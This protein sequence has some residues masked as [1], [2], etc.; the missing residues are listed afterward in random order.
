MSNLQ[1][2][3]K[4]VAWLEQ[5]GLSNSQ[6]IAEMYFGDMPIDEWQERPIEDWGGAL[7]AHWRFGQCRPEG[8]ALLRIYNP[9]QAE[10]GWQCAHTV[11]E[12]VHEDMPFLVD[13][14]GM[15]LNALKYN[16]LAVI[17]PVIPL[18]RD[19]NGTVSQLQVGAT[20]ES[21]MHFEL[22][23]ISDPALLTTLQ[24]Q[25][26]QALSAIA[27]SVAD[28]SK[29]LGGVEQTLQELRSGELADSTSNVKEAAA[30]LEWLLDGHFVFLGLRK[31]KFVAGELLLQAGSGLG[32]LRDH[33]GSDVV[34]RIWS[35]LSQEQ[36]DI[37]YANNRVVMLTKSD[38]RS[39]IHRPAYLD[40]ILVRTLDQTGQ[41]LGETRIV[42][43]YSASAYST[44]PRQIPILRQKIEH[45][46]QNSGADLSGYRGKALLNTLETYPRDELIEIEVPEL[47]RI[48][49]GIVSLH[50][51]SRVRVF[52]RDDIYQRYVS[53]MVFVPRDNYSTEVRIKIETLLL[54]KLAGTSAEYTVLLGEAPLARLHYLIRRPVG[55]RGAYDASLIEQEIANLAQ[56][57]TDGL[58]RELIHIHGEEKGARLYQKYQSGFSAAY[59]ADFSPR[60]A[61]HDIDALEQSQRE[62]FAVSLSAAN[63][64]DPTIWRF[65]LYRQ[66][67]IELSDCLPLLE[68]LGLRV[69]DERP[70]PVVTSDHEPL[71]IMDIGIRLPPGASLESPTERQRMMD[72]F[73][74]L[75]NGQAENDSFN[76]LTLLAGL[77]WREVLILRAYARFLKQVAFKYGVETI[78]DCLLKYPSYSKQLV[79]A[80]SMLH[81]PDESQ[82]GVAEIVLEEIEQAA[83]VL[84]N[85]D[86]ERILTGFVQSVRATLR[87]NFFQ[88]HAGLS[89]PYLALKIA[90]PQLSFM[91]Q[92]VPMCE[93]FVYSPQLEGVHLRGGKV[94]RGGLRWSDRR[95]D[96]RTEVLG[97]VKAQMVKNTVIVPVGS[98]G[99]FIV[100]NPPLD[101]D[102][103]LAAGTR[104][105][106]TFIGGL[107]D[108]TDNLR[109]GQIIPPT[110]VRRRD[111]D[112]P[113]LVV[114]ADK[115]TA[116]FSD[117]ANQIAQ[118]YGFWLDDAFA[119]GGSVGYDHKKMG[120]T[121]R[122]AWV[123]VERSFRELGLDTRKEPFSVV[124]IGDM[125][126]DVFGN[127]LLRSPCAKLVAAFD[128]RHIFIDPAPDL[129]ISFAERNRLFVLP[130]SSWADYNPALI[131]KGGGVW[132]RSAKT[133]A[134]ST[135]IKGMLGVEADQLEPSVLIQ[136]ILKAP[137]DLLYNG[138]IG[139]Y[140]KA[141]SQS[142]AEANDRGN[143]AVRIDGRDL[144]CRV[145]AEGGN[146]GFT[147]LGR[148]EYAAQGGRIYTDAI[149]NSA[150]V[151]CSDHEVNIKIL[152]GKLIASGDLTLKQ[153]NEIL[154][155]MTED[156][157]LQVLRD[158]ELQTLAISLEHQQ[159]HSLLSVHTRL[160]SH[161]EKAGKLSRRI[162]YLP[163]DSALAE[164]Q[165]AG[166]GLYRPELAVLL[167]YAKIVLNQDLLAESLIDNPHWDG[168]LVEY[169]PS[170][171]SARF[172]T[173]I[174]S[175]P[176]RREI[177]ATI[178][179]NHIVNRFGLS[180]VYR[181]QEETECSASCV[182]E[183]FYIAEQLLNSESLAQ[184]VEALDARAP[185]EV[186]IE[187]LL[188]I[189][190]YTERVARWLLMHPLNAAE[191]DHLHTSAALT[192][193]LAPEWL[194]ASP[195][196]QEQKSLLLNVGV[197]ADLAMKVLLLQEI[198]PLLE[199]ARYGNDTGQLADRLKLHLALAEQLQLTWL[200]GAIEQLPRANRWQTL[201]R[202]AV[203]DD[204]A[205]FQTLL[206]QQVWQQGQN[207]QCLQVWLDSNRLTIERILAMFAELR[208]CTP[209]LAMI[210]AAVRELRQ[211]L[212]A[213]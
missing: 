68:N 5:H 81:H 169:F 50:E 40:T 85:I 133:I 112:D 58:K 93:I 26:E 188:Q 126:G 103:L 25:I 152:L 168:V 147:Q 107:L 43:L 192:L 123:S 91:P 157:G 41:L 151:D 183:A 45:V 74:A 23:R 57:W 80:F 184:E 109:D 148:V 55:V 38:R 207:E 143:D 140:V 186:Q 6:Q 150:G 139:T 8:E 97:L 2:L 208:S 145:V 118:E 83:K 12:I 90:S 100:K 111:G 122:G 21:W 98:K 17:H 60:I 77:A 14:V 69:L 34:S 134:L 13:S 137:V 64:L 53:V 210:S 47:T 193:P 119:S 115:G 44:P 4:L 18:S 180:A 27:A 203:R 9:S 110:N 135:E 161:L 99:G 10:H 101:R 105:Y 56:R 106:Q 79:N 213:A 154:V 102:A 114:A 174:A 86:E 48:A 176:L 95:E 160:M 54:E 71:S 76:R 127:G 185:A 171:L 167:A 116:T 39:I 78:A 66:H 3:S 206:T 191:S 198:Q 200:H 195:R 46:V 120:I 20:K 165:A 144:R 178:L 28:W 89:K 29:M 187:L 84:P 51:R 173:A 42:G 22:N 124:G 155:S 166:L 181:L 159:A 32:V 130:R 37:A 182:V 196:H 104:C 211:R 142:H 149:D 52:F 153:R 190:R 7:L 65:K 88:Q 59:C 199:M 19:A 73:I 194:A 162:E 61:V 179:T 129:A 204:L 33:G 125:S 212:C 197:P 175:H 189:R 67:A 209:D 172:P 72:S 156:V 121:A 87:T 128:H 138:G 117:I 82:E 31:Y 164:R 132:P 170:L 49:L 1:H 96:F 62:H 94:A 70:Y 136:A 141:S 158:N 16:A 177:I 92:P 163:D 36:R 63:S 108:L 35:S 113:Y 202:M 205:A 131:S 11:I 75:F 15:A 201:A 30:Y 24:Q 146:L